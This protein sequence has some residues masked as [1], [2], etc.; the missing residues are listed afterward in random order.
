[1]PLAA[2][3]PLSGS[4]G[5]VA[6]VASGS[7]RGHQRISNDQLGQRVDTNDEWIR[8]R[9]GIQSRQICGPEQSLSSL[10]AEAGR[11]ALD[12][13][14][15]DANS[16]DLVLLATSTP[17]DLFG[18]ALE[19]LTSAG[20]EIIVIYLSASCSTLPSVR[21]FSEHANRAA[22]QRSVSLVE[23][24]CPETRPTFVQALAERVRDAERSATWTVPEDR[25]RAEVQ[26]MW[27]TFDGGT[28]VGAG[29]EE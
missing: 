2:S 3:T 10:G 18:S 4:S 24:P 22:R 14:G 6:L 20:E 19:D 25:I 8:T 1:M 5:G 23:A 28:P 16:L 9:T 15:W 26:A 27:A 17:D 11:Q 21:R 29:A 13:A 7:A 12:M